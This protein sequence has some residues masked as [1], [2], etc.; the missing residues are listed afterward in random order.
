MNVTADKR[1]QVLGLFNVSEAA[2]RIGQPIQ[3]LHRDIKAGRL[4]TPTVPLGKRHYFT[5]DD[6]TILKQHVQEKS[7]S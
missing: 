7:R 3:K 2:R 6:L 1:R 4:P 5:E